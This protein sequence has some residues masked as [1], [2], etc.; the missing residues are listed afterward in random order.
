LEHLGFVE[1][2]DIPTDRVDVVV[3]DG[4]T[5][6]IALKTAEG[7]ARLYYNFLKEA[8]MSSFLA[9]I[10]YVLAQS[11]VKKVLDRT[12]PRRHNGAVFL[13]LNGTV[14]KSHGGTD[15][16][17]FANAI[18]VGVDMVQRGVNEQIAANLTTIA[19]SDGG[20]L[21]ETE[22]AAVPE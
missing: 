2:T 11:A 16:F 20:A 10:G 22:K 13:G 9:K 7:T 17:G 12:D 21:E 19:T 14:V 1:G 4:F 18:E 15:A 5:G 6:N 8:V 3:T